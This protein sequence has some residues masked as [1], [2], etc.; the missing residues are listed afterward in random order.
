MV[1][2]WQ[3]LSWISMSVPIYTK[4]STCKFYLN[5]Y[6]T[7]SMCRKIIVLNEKPCVVYYP[8]NELIEHALYVD[9]EKARNS[10]GLCGENAS[11][12]ERRLN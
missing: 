11:F 3:G 12:Y 1:S 9:V 10:T 8:N 5:S 2:F 4:C 6:K 7:P